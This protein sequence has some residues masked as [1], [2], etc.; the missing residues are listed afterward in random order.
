MKQIKGYE[1]F[2]FYI[3]TNLKSGHGFDFAESIDANGEGESWSRVEIIPFCD[4]WLLAIG[5]YGGRSRA[6]AWDDE[7]TWGD[8][9]CLVEGFFEYM[10]MEEA[11]IE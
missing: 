1:D 9:K 2:A 7:T 4:S 10:Q 11:F 5:G 8:V 3:W 6:I